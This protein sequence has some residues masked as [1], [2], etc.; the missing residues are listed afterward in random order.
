[1]AEEL[2]NGRQLVERNEDGKLVLAAQVENII[3]LCEES[4]REANSNYD[5]V[6]QS[7]IT[8]MLDNNIKT[9]KVGKY[10]FSVREPKE[11]WNF[12]VDKFINEENE[13]IV[14]AFSSV[15][16][17]TSKVFDMEKFR[18]E[19]PDI[20]EK[21]LVEQKEEKLVVDDNKLWSTLRNVWEKYATKE[22][23]KPATITIKKVE[24]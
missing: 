10:K 3:D 14:V 22:E 23:P 15:E 7:I 2:I 13:E 18:T 16:T 19:C 21:Y 12:D 5:F 6:K 4:V 24:E 17:T 9:A 1:M 11:K 20:Y 8:A